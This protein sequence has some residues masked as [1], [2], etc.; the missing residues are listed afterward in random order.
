MGVGV[1]GKAVG[2]YAAEVCVSISDAS[3]AAVVPMISG[4][5]VGFTACVGTQATE[6]N[7]TQTKSDRTIIF[8]NFT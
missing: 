6:K 1:T 5:E 7:T 8:L 2:V 3:C 4:V